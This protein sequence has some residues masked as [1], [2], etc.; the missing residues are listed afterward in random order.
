MKKIV[1][2]LGLL[3]IFFSCDLETEL[4]SSYS[5]DV[6]WRN[7]ENLELYV[8]GFYGILRDNAEIYNNELSDGLSDILKYS[9]T[10][11]NPTTYQNK[12]LLMENTISP[13]S[14]VL[15][16]W[17]GNYGRIKAQNE[18]LYDVKHK[19]KHLDE[20]FIEIR[21]AEVRFLRAYAYYKIIRNHGGV[22]LRLENTGIDGGLDTEKDAHKPRLT[23]E[24]SWN[25][26][27]KELEEIAPI[28]SENKWNDKEYGRITGGAVYALLSRCA[29]YAKQFDKVITAGNEI[30]KMGY[31]LED[32]YANV[33]SNPNSKEIILPVLFKYPEFVHYFDRYFGPTGDFADRGGWA[34]PTEELVQNYQ[35][36]ENGTYV[37][38]DWSNP[39]HRANPYENREPRFYASILYNGANWRGRKIETFVGGKDGFTVYD[40]NT[41][42]PGCV[43]GYFMRKYLQES[44]NTVDYGSDTYW[45]EFRLAEVLLNMAEAYAQKGDV[46]TG[47]K[48]L[49][50]I[51]KR[52]GVPLY[53]E[54]S[55]L[56]IFM[57]KLEKERMLELAFEGH[58][59]WDIRRWRRAE[60][61]IHGK[62]AHGVKITKDSNNNLIYEIIPI[63]QKDRYFPEKYY[64][65]PVPQS[66]IDRNNLCEQTPPW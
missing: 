62:R 4:T 39:S 33:F 18:F 9:V 47:Y 36:K 13:L 30:E 66:E 8:K 44:N 42:F 2:L 12:V 25:F 61:V 24:E 28:L 35:I 34:C 19:A 1:Y 23:E 55:N 11:L 27:I 65:I 31:E 56:D 50:K 63:E 45:I 17:G 6:A 14:G 5:E 54:G 32:N 43:T 16:N 29:L 40:F 7:E 53:P 20:N 10:N 52:A 38:F 46:P 37:D 49:N 64:Y 26:V 15:Q 3:I 58:R 60:E 41:D 59:Y 51:R 22:I 48:Y 57:E 21:K